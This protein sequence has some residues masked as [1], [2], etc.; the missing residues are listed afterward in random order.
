MTNSTDPFSASVIPFQAPEQIVQTAIQEDA[1]GI[2]LSILSGSHLSVV[3]EVI[4]RMECAGLRDIPV[5]VGGIIPPEDAQALREAGVAGVYTPK[6]FE[7]NRIM[8]DLV[9]IVE[10]GA[11]RAQR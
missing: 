10:H 7:L 8:A 3:R 4:E 1:D 9:R 6:D 11:E 5:V 2:G